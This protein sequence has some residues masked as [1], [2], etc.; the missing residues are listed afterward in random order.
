[1]YGEGYAK[2]FQVKYLIYMDGGTVNYAR[3]KYLTAAVYALSISDEGL[4]T[5]FIYIIR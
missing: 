3:N 4:V 5:D 2:P 1:M